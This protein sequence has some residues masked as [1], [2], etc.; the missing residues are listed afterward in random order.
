MKTVPGIGQLF[1]DLE[2]HA[3]SLQFHGENLKAAE[4]HSN[5]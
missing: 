5:Y 4:S 2:Y 3:T 1:K